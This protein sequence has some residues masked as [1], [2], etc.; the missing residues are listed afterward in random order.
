MEFVVFSLQNCWDRKRPGL[1]VSLES[2]TWEQIE[3]VDDGQWWT[4]ANRRQFR[5][6]SHSLAWNGDLHLVYHVHHLAMSQHIHPNYESERHNPRKVALWGARTKESWE[7]A[8]FPASISDLSK[9]F[10]N[11]N[12]NFEANCWPR[13]AISCSGS[14]V[15]PTCSPYRK[16]S[17]ALDRVWRYDPGTIGSPGGGCCARWKVA[18]GAP[19][20]VAADGTRSVPRKKGRG[21][22]LFSC[23]RMQYLHGKKNTPPMRI[24][25]WRSYHNHVQELNA[26]L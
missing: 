25:A 3:L 20:H 19:K 5:S 14:P 9:I 23:I 24:N 12:L 7:L 10:L 13:E 17:W 8:Y 2:R 11:L 18:V 6:F 4:N 21:N 1:L 16:A 22:A 15:S 26:I